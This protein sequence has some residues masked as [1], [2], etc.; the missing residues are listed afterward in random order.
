ME[1][2]K[3]NPISKDKKNM[4]KIVYDCAG[5]LAKT[6]NQI[7][8]RPYISAPR[9]WNNLAYDK[10]GTISQ[11]PRDKVTILFKGDGTNIQHTGIY[12]KNDRFVHAKGTD[13]GVL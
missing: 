8:I 4:G 5:L 12:I 6:F 2:A 1:K 3:F 10:K 11:I 9:N 13:Y 7:G